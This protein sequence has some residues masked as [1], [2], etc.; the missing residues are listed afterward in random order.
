MFSVDPDAPMPGFPGVRGQYH[1][2]G[3]RTVPTHKIVDI[4][5]F[6]TRNGKVYRKSGFSPKGK[7]AFSRSTVSTRAALHAAWHVFDVSGPL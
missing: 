3:V 1:Y 2:A 5:E 7:R 6:P 4:D